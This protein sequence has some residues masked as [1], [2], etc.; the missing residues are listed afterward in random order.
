MA[1][2]R[3]L[4]LI[5]SQPPLSLTAF[6]SIIIVGVGSNNFDRMDILDGN[7]LRCSA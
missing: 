2:I 7:M 3:L 5:T 6:Y 4:S 1:L